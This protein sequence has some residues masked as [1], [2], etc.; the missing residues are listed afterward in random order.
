VTDSKT[1]TAPRRLSETELTTVVGGIIRNGGAGNDTL[2]GWTGSDLLAGGADNDFLNG[3]DGNDL[4]LGEA[5]EDL[6]SGWDGDDRLDGGADND[7]LLGGTGDDTLLGG[8]G[9]D[10]L[11]GGVG[12]DTV[13]GGA[14]DDTVIVFPREERDTASGGSGIDTLRLEATADAYRIEFT[15]GGFVPN[16]DGQQLQAGSAGIVTFVAGGSVTFSEFERIVHL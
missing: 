15:S 10:R 12:N 6:L 14:G 11:D 9:N 4:L 2:Y 3:W 7:L 1:R 8:A 5:G 16:G 13:N